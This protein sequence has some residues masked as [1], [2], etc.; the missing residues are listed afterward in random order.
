[1]SL[2]LAGCAN[3]AN[4]KTG[5]PEDEIK[6]YNSYVEILNGTDWLLNMGQSY[7]SEFGKEE[8]LRIKKDFSGFV[9]FVRTKENEKFNLYEFHKDKHTQLQKKYSSSKPSYGDADTKMATLCDKEESFIELYFNEVNT[10]Y[11]NK[12]YEKDNFAKGRELHKRMIESYKELIRAIK[13]FNIAFQS[14]LMEH[15]GADLPKY[16]KNGQTVHYYALST[17]MN[18]NEITNMFDEIEGQGKD[19]LEV[20][21]GKYDEVYNKFVSNLAELKKAY[22]DKEILKKDG[23]TS[24]QIGWIKSV[25]D[26]ADIIQKEATKTRNMIKAG[27]SEIDTGERKGLSTMGRNYP[28]DKIRRELSD[29][30]SKYNITIEKKDK[31]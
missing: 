27:T 15:Y 1:M 6:K 23:Y 16:Q 2:L 3:V 17:V 8:E 13:E 21:P 28:I 12:E 11:T 18:A 22:G 24:D 19:F 20:D 7:F 30:I 26:D 9:L 10:Y 5:S 25:I 29:L 31:K 14:K 4:I